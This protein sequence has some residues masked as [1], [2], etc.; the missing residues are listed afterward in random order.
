VHTNGSFVFIAFSIAN[1]FFFFCA[2]VFFFS[3]VDKKRRGSQQKQD[4]SQSRDTKHN[5]R[6]HVAGDATRRG[7]CETG[8]GRASARTAAAAPAAEAAVA[9]ATTTATATA[10]DGGVRAGEAEGCGEV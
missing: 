1:Y 8:S 2:F 6:A 4:A 9:A 5:G 3:C 10:R 7:C